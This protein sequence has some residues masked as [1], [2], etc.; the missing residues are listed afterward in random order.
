MH[1]GHGQSASIA[2]DVP[3]SWDGTRTS[4]STQCNSNEPH[5][6]LTGSELPKTPGDDIQVSDSSYQFWSPHDEN[7]VRTHFAPPERRV[8]TNTIDRKF[9]TIKCSLNSVYTPSKVFSKVR[10]LYGS[11]LKVEKYK[12]SLPKYLLPKRITNRGLVHEDE[13]IL[14]ER[15]QHLLKDGVHRGLGEIKSCLRGTDLLAKYCL[16]QIQ[17][18]LTYWTRQVKEHQGNM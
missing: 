13:I 7:I 18:K 14:Y 6:T 9:Q 1:E 8:C 10:R 15:C 17:T 4:E 3:S 12:S 5:A 2:S 16:S 11:P